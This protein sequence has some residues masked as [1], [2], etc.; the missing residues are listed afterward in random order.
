MKVSTK[1]IGWVAGIGSIVGLCVGIGG[2]ILVI[3]SVTDKIPISSCLSNGWGISAEHQNAFVKGQ[4]LVGVPFLVAG[5]LAMVG[6]VIGGWA[7]F[8]GNKKGLTCTAWA[9]GISFVFA[10]QGAYL[11]FK[12]AKSFGELCNEFDCSDSC[13]S[14]WKECMKNDVCCDC[15]KGIGQEAAMCKSAHDWACNCESRKTAGFI[16]AIFTCFFTIIS[17]SLGCGATCLCQD[18]FE[19][20]QMAADE[21]MEGVFGGE[22]QGNVVGKPVEAE[23]IEPDP[24][25]DDL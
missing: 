4:L 2:I 1:V 3:I 20:A 6:G 10:L 14:L 5:V 7:G 25:K 8:A 19:Y 18:M 12:L 22:V 13:G 11:A 16:L 15:T 17:S 24:R 9:E 21:E 23:E